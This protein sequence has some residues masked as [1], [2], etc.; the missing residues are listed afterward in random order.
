METQRGN[1]PIAKSILNRGW[2]MARRHKLKMLAASARHNLLL[3]TTETGEYE[4]AE[5]HAAAALA[6]YGPRAKN[7]YALAHDWAFIWLVQGYFA[8]AIPIFEAVRPFIHTPA[9]RSLL[10][11]N[12]ARAYAGQEN[13]SGFDNAAGEVLRLVQVTAENSAGALDSI[14]EG[15][16]LLGRFKEARELSIRALHL[17]LGREEHGLVCE[18]RERL[19]R[20]EEGLPSV[21]AREPPPGSPIPTIVEEILERLRRSAR[22]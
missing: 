1:H 19:R 16:L 15:A 17:A 3:V 20:I 11:S 18:I 12:L 6:L 14:A 13:P 10:L 7:L 21:S 5:F 4:E 8:P 9:L 22:S 2:R